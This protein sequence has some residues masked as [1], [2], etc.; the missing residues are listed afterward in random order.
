MDYNFGEKHKQIQAKGEIWDADVF[1]NEEHWKQLINLRDDNL[2]QYHQC[3]IKGEARLLV[4]DLCEG[5]MLDYCRKNLDD[6]VTLF[7]KGIDI[8]WQIT[9]GMDYLNRHKIHHGNLMLENVLF[10]KRN[11][12][13]KRI[14]V[15]LAGYGYKLFQNQN[16]IKDD[17]YQLGCLYY[18]AAT[19][20]EAKPNE[21]ISLEILTEIELNHRSL[22]LDLI[23]LLIKGEDGLKLEIATLLRHPLFIRSSEDGKARLIK[24]LT[25]GELSHVWN[26]KQKLQEWKMALTEQTELH[27][28]DF[29]DLT[30]ILVSEKKDIGQQVAEALRTTPKSFAEYIWY[31]ATDLSFS[32]ETNKVQ[33]I[34]IYELLGEGNYGKVFKCNYTDGDGKRYL[35][36]CKKC[37][38][39]RE[40]NDMFDRE[41]QT[42][43]QLNHLFVIKYLDMIE[44]SSKKFIVMEL[45]DGSLKDYFDGKLEGIPKDSLDDK[46]LVSQ[47]A[48]G[49]A[50]IHDKGII[51]KDL[52]LENILLKRQSPRLVLAK[53]ADFGF[54]KELK[55]GKAEFSETLH[56]GTESYMAP[57]LL[58]ADKG[59]YPAS[60][61]SD[62]YALGIIIVRIIKKGDPPFGLNKLLR[63]A[64]MVRGLVPPELQEFSWDLIDLIVKLT[65]KEP[66]KRPEMT[67]VL[68]HPYFVLTNDRTKRYFV[69]KLCNDFN[70]LSKDD[71]T[72]QLKK[73]FNQHNFQ[74]WYS[75]T[76]SGY[77]DTDD[78]IEEMSKNLSLFRK[79][80]PEIQ[81]DTLYPAKKYAEKI[82]E[83]I[84]SNYDANI[85]SQINQVSH[86]IDLENV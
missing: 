15:K 84:S 28:E 12:S 5:S 74:E 64:S 51:H 26:S 78:E 24:D 46:I 62:V 50:Y 30:D 67:L 35:T 10:W 7:V 59:A 75:T 45:C 76:L 22:A 80:D 68:R 1:Q 32:E 49:V 40:G 53:I 19:K 81:A 37:N 16:N 6:N 55:P 52:K 39:K 63:T 58:T 31:L 44:K 72:K 57:E 42:L 70:L 85:E 25:D 60:F 3:S 20:D 77:P 43:R 13:S 66:E 27:D 14:V 18:S 86:K 82:K 8:I 56:P 33:S 79:Y 17:L 71:R 2:V 47:I 9:C 48:L 69:D 61:A 41:I 83:A 65:E 34:E 11:S 4:M 21:L 73:I 29:H 38:T 54:A 36:A 23:H